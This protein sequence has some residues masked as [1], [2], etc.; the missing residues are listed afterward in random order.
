MSVKFN[1]NLKLK[2]EKFS[3]GSEAGNKH[4]LEINFY[5]PTTQKCD[6]NLTTIIDFLG[7]KLALN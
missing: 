1:Y 5:I 7:F 4:L 3:T 6:Y 2:S